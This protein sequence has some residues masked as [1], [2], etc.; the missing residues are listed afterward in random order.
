[1]RARSRRRCGW[2]TEGWPTEQ[3]RRGA[4]RAGKDPPTAA[5]QQRC[6]TDALREAG[7]RQGDLRLVR[8][9]HL[10]PPVGRAVLGDDGHLMIHVPYKGSALAD[11]DLM[12]GRAADVRQRADRAAFRQ[13]RQAQ[14]PGRDRRQ[15]MNA[16]PNVPTMEE[17]GLHGFVTGSGSACSCRR[18]RRARSSRARGHHHAA[19]RRPDIRALLLNAGAELDPA[20]ARVPGLAL[21]EKRAGRR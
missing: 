10:H 3:D 18:A 20:G 19:V 12:A 4:H 14:G 6:R 8:Y 5:G 1:M 16:L 13:G 21:A 17:A 7:Q 11:T 9:R 2:P 15:R